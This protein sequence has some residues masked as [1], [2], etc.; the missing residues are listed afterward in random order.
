MANVKIKVTN[1][2]VG[3]YTDG[4][5][6]EVDEKTAKH[7]E[8]IRYAKIVPKG[9]KLTPAKDAGKTDDDEQDDT[10]NDGGGDDK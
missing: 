3:G 5:V 6:I 4:D 8:S 9:T 7:L 1:A 2:V 10:T